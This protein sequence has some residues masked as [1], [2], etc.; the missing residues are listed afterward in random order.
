MSST[1]AQLTCVEAAKNAFNTAM[2]DANEAAP[3]IDVE[4]NKKKAAVQ[5]RVEAAEEALKNTK[6][7]VDK[8]AAKM[9]AD[10]ATMTDTEFAALMEPVEAAEKAV[11]KA[12]QD[13]V[14]EL[15]AI[16]AAAEAALEELMEHVKAA[17]DA[18][19]AAKKSCVEA[20]EK[21]VAA[22]YDRLYSIYGGD[23]IDP[24]VAEY[25]RTRFGHVLIEGLV[26]LSDVLEAAKKDLMTSG[27]KADYAVKVASANLDAERNRLHDMGIDADEKFAKILGDMRCAE[28][29]NDV[30]V[31]EQIKWFVNLQHLHERAI[32]RRNAM[33]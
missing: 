31:P 1:F 12:F 21:A 26:G 32:V 15:E 16:D 25:Y 20:A 8:T 22:E 7:D 14:D 3:K 9:D 28:S 5:A 19:E 30:Q 33:R 13:A 4:T 2:A 6:A 11:E 27:E 29:L 23:L 24:L 18:L 10:G 17:K